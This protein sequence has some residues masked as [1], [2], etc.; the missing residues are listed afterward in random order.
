MVLSLTARSFNVS[1]SLEM[2]KKVKCNDEEW[3]NSGLK[4]LL[5]IIL[6]WVLIVI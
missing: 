5:L 1:A 6:N 4:L 3:V 2:L